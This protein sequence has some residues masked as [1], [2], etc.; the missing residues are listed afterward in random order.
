M[1]E[2]SEFKEQAAVV[3]ISEVKGDKQEYVKQMVQKYGTKEKR[4]G[5]G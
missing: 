5:E 4:N 2:I 3:D 1:G